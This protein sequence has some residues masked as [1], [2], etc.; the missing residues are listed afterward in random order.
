MKK[1]GQEMYVTFSS[2]VSRQL[3]DR[4]GPV[5]NV[6]RARYCAECGCAY[7]PDASTTHGLCHTCEELVVLVK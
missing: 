2:E 3:R 7:V 5:A 6:C 4:S 1:R